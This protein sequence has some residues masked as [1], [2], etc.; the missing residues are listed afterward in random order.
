[1]NATVASWF[2][3]GHQLALL[4]RH[5]TLG[6]VVT[7]PVHSYEVAAAFLSDETEGA[8][9]LPEFHTTANALAAAPARGLNRYI[10]WYSTS[11]Q[12]LRRIG[13]THVLLIFG[14]MTGYAA[15][16]LR[17]AASNTAHTLCFVQRLMC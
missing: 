16:D 10:C 8:K 1:V 9:V 3:T 13:V 15:D 12:I 17:C 5:A 2:G 14:G 11:P 4:A 7:D 6:R